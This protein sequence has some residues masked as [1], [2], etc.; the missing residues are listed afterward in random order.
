M[1]HVDND[2]ISETVV[3]SIDRSTPLQMETEKMDFPGLEIYL[4]RQRVYRNGTL[5]PLTSREFHTLVYLARHPGWVCTADA[6]YESVWQ[7]PCENRG[8]AIANVISQLR[9]KLSPDAPKDGYI[10]TIIGDGYKFVVP[11]SE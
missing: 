10:Q 1:R 8:T 2:I 9:H 5:V 11:E 6:I 3:V 7:E 4:K